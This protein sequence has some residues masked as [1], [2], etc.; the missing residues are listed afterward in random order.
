MRGFTPFCDRLEEILTRTHVVT[1]NL[2]FRIK[3][4]TSPAEEEQPS[5]TVEEKFSC[6]DGSN[7]NLAHPA[8]GKPMSPLLRLLPADYA[9]GFDAP[10]GPNRPSPRVISNVLFDQRVPVPSHEGL[11]DFHVHF[12]Q[13]V[14]HDT[15]FAT[16]YANFLTTDNLGIP[17]PE[18]DPWFDPHSNGKEIM[19]FR[20]SAQLQTTGKLHGVPREQVSVCS[21]SARQ[22]SEVFVRSDKMR[23]ESASSSLSLWVRNKGDSW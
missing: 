1:N 20:R 18:G 12:G 14:A 5:E 16:P 22:T 15:D 17:V 7:N 6:L 13:L 2:F 9:D 8:W 11:N 19:R 10:A 23:R 4:V 3:Q 21:G